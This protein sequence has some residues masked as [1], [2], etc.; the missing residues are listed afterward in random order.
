VALA[1]PRVALAQIVWRSR[2]SCGA[3]AARVAL[4]QLVWPAAR[5][6]W[7]SRGSRGRP[8]VFTQLVWHWRSRSG[9]CVELGELRETADP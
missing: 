5:L 9:R 7:R 6:A 2:G 1:R 4:A 3:R 8:G